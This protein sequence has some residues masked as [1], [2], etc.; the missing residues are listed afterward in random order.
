MYRAG[1]ASFLE[2]KSDMQRVLRSQS[3]V[4]LNIFL[5]WQ[6]ICALALTVSVF[7]SHTDNMIFMAIMLG[8][9][10]TASAVYML[11]G[12]LDYMGKKE[13]YSREFIFWGALATYMLPLVAGLFF[14]PSALATYRTGYLLHIL[15]SLIVIHRT[16]FLGKKI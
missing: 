16:L 4:A 10:G 5:I 9:L 11:K 3:F 6:M 1:L 7:S 8:L 13:A 15:I 2:L 12:T 14:Y